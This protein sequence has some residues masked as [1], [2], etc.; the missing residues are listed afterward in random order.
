MAAYWEIAAH[1]AYDMFSQYSDNI[2]NLVLTSPM[3]LEWELFLIAPFPDHCL[4]LL[5]EHVDAFDTDKFIP[6]YS[7]NKATDV[8]DGN[9][10]AGY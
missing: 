7:A 1:S 9:L 5:F 4:L 3:F 2:V 8:D 6:G 10:L